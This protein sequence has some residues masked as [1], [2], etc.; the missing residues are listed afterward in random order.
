MDLIY[1]HLKSD[2]AF[3]EVKD[4][5]KANGFI[6]LKDSGISLGIPKEKYES[7]NRDE[8]TNNT[9]VMIVCW[10]KNKDQAIGEKLIRQ[11][12]KEIRLS[13]GSDDGRLLN[14]GV[15]GGFVSEINY[16][17]TEA[18]NSLLLHLAEITY[19]VEY[20]ESRMRPEQANTVLSISNDIDI[21]R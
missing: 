10:L 6:S 3:S 12:A 20:Y 15:I 18:Q 4:W 14:G 8:D 9:T 5:N 13:L 19:E 1:D 17:T 7:L 16:L 11:L 21:E 2:P